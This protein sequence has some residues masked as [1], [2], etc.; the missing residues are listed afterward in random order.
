MHRFHENSTPFYNRALSIHRF[1]YSRGEGGGA[2]LETVPPWIPSDDGKSF[3]DPTKVVTGS[4][5]NELVSAFFKQVKKK[6]YFSFFIYFRHHF[7]FRKYH[8]TIPHPSILS[9]ATIPLR[10]RNM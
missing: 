8:P 6:D 1:W 2:V 5:Y 7:S 9:N 3:Q 10:Q 4:T